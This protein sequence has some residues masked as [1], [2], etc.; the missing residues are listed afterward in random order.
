[1][2]ALNTR[3]PTLCAHCCCAW[4][5]GAVRGRRRAGQAGA[6]RSPPRRACRPAAEG[7]R[8]ALRPANPGGGRVRHGSV[9]PSGEQSARGSTHVFEDAGACVRAH[10][11]EVCARS[12][13]GFERFRRPCGPLQG[14]AKRPQSG[15]VRLSTLVP[16]T[17]SK[18]AALAGQQHSAPSHATVVV[19]LEAPMR[20]CAPSARER[21]GKSI[22][23]PR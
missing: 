20:A 7:G 19:S 2:T 16:L 12:L 23:E 1:M 15:G 14:T 5:R 11:L 22:K 10:T 18:E 17:P 3:G 6:L 4:R 13:A 21:S 9:L 8:A